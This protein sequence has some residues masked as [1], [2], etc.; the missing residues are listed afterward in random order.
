MPNEKFNLF[1]S[2]IQWYNLKSL[3]NQYLFALV[4]L[5]N[6]MY[7]EIAFICSDTLESL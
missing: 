6:K 1:L 4:C 7:P 3:N 2:R 5:E